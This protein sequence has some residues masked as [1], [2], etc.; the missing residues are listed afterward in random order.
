VAAAASRAEAVADAIRQLE[1]VTRNATFVRTFPYPTGTAYGLLLDE[2]QPGWPR[3]TTSGSDLP[4]MVATAAG[5]RP[6][7]DAASATAA[8]TRYGGPDLRAAEEVRDAEQ[9]A[10]VAALRRVF[11]DGPVLVLPGG[12]RNSFTTAGMTPIPGEG[13]VYPSLRSTAPWGQLT[14]ERALVSAERGTIRVPAPPPETTARAATEPPHRLEGEGWSLELAPDWTI[15]P[16]PRPGDY[17]V[18][19]DA[20]N[21]P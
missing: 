12:G 14:A 20:P 9:R 16:G 18:A 21:P 11:V 1:E 2:W 3:T 4:G 15:R 13:T 6:S 5:I 8:A 7:A 10:R 19:K 17:T